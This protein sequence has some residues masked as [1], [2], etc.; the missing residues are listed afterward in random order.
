MKHRFLPVL[1]LFIGIIFVISL[2]IKIPYTVGAENKKEYI[3]YVRECCDI[4][5]QYGTDRYGDIHAPILV[6][7]LDVNTR[8]CPKNPLP[9]DEQYR[10]TRRERRNPA[11]AN[12][13]VDQPLLRTLYLLSAET[14]DNRYRMFAQE[15]MDYYMKNLVDEKG[16]F[17]WGWHRH[18]DV[19]EDKFDGHQGNHHEIQAVTAIEWERLWNVNPQAVQKEIEA[20]WTWHVIDKESGEVNRH[21][22]GQRGCDFTISAGAY[23]EAFTFLYNK[24][25]KEM[26]LDRAK[27]L[28]HYYWNQRDRVTNLIP[29]RPNAGKDRF[30]GGS[31]VTSV[32]G[33]YCHS[34]LKAYALTGEDFFR[35]N[36]LAYLGAYSKYGYD[37]NNELFWGALKLDGTPIAGPRLLEGYAQYEPRGYLD[38][39]EP[40]LLGYQYPVYTAQA[41]AYAYQLTKDQE[42]LA[43]ATHF[44]NWMIKTPPSQGCM[45]ESWYKE[46]ATDYAP[47]GTYADKYG[48]AIS[49]YIHMY[50]LTREQ[51]YLNQA[52]IMADSAIQKLY[53][54]G[55]FRGHPAKPYYEAADGVGYLLYALLELDQVIK[56]PKDILSTLEITLGRQGVKMGLDNW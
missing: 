38:L 56:N 31:F 33:L 34:L 47:H 54:K 5:L 40:Y 44:A 19:Y 2:S 7:I 45:K 11:G 35:N 25:K 16:L 32:T 29:E 49:F 23:I 43:A 53:F 12:M 1:L 17:W 37:S 22:D 9:L 6:S 41:Y 55:L 20:I 4:L 39:W 26:W 10:V 30:D 51:E 24:T 52:M 21:D 8:E 48:R 28:A 46:Y 14:G 50:I 15:Y 36:A 18:Y 27:L 3:D 42:M 13:I